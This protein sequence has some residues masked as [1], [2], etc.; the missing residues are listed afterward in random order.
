MKKI[1]VLMIL[2]LFV[3]CITACSGENK[4][5]NDVEPTQGTAGV[6]ENNGSD[7][8]ISPDGQ[9]P[10]DSDVDVPTEKYVV[11]L[12]PGHGGGYS[13]AVNGELVEKELSLK[14]GLYIKEYLEENYEQIE[15]CLTRETDSALSGDI[16][17]DLE[18][19]AQFAQ[20]M[21]AD[22][23]V[24]LHLNASEA[25]NLS[26]A[27]AF[28]SNRDNVT[29]ESKLLADFIL[30]E[31]EALGLSNE[32]SRT[33]DSNDMVDENG[34]ALDYYAINRHCAARDIPGI[35]IE[36][37]FIDNETDLKFIDSEE[38]LKNLAIADA[39]GIAAY[40]LGKQ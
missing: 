5:G 37:C 11:V 19:R 27:M 40:L 2:S 14:I 34:D 1:T 36:H 29:G 10:S 28:I 33:R 38:M 17:E 22:I 18:M 15:V 39:E 25:H 12:D 7:P 32:K 8:V 26:G 30:G 9:Q 20:D 4:G 6:D 24:S 16:V 13:G 3:L 35:I 21:N 23:L 31:L